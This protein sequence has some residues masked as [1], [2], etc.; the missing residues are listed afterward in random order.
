[1]ASFN[2]KDSF[3]KRAPT[4]SWY[5]DVNDLTKLQKSRFDKI[6]PK[7][8]K[9]PDLLAHELYGTV[10][11]WWVFALRNPDLLIDPIED[12]ASGLSIYIP[13]KETIDRVI[14]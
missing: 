8:S 4:N 2:S 1:M 6:E 12:F 5:L 11:L 10:R 7:F 9:R 13:T 14:N 3:L